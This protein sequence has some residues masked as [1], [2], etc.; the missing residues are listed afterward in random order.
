MLLIFETI[1]RCRRRLF[2]FSF[3]M[4]SRSHSLLFFY[5]FTGIQYISFIL[6]S[7][8]FNGTVMCVQKGTFIFIC[9]TIANRAP[10]QQLSQHKH[11]AEHVDFK[12]FDRT[13]CNA[14]ESGCAHQMKSPLL[15]YVLYY[16]CYFFKTNICRFRWWFFPSTLTSSTQTDE[17]EDIFLEMLNEILSSNANS[18]VWLP[19]S[20]T[21]ELWIYLV[22]WSHSTFSTLR[23]TT[24]RLFE[25]TP[26]FLYVS[27]TDVC[28]NEDARILSNVQKCRHLSC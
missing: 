22:Y 13:T 16:K 5:L 21:V 8:R 10:L 7:Y 12:Y 15:Q 27:H 23:A 14:N 11:P 6:H 20:D 9:S 24:L 4:C 18:L 3:F 28:M 2:F 19:S 25:N 17:S 26:I 1:R